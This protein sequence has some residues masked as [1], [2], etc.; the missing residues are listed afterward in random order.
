MAIY[1]RGDLHANARNEMKQ[2]NSDNFPQ[3][4]EMTKEDYVIIC[5]DFG[6]VWFAEE[7]KEEKWWLNWLEERNFTTL[8][9]DGNHDNHDRLD[10]YPVENWHGGK[11]HFIRPS[12]IHLMR[13][14]V[15]EI[16][17][18]TFTTMGGA[19]SHDIQ[20][21]V[22][23]PADYATREDMI[24]DINRKMRAKGGWQYFLYRIKGESWWEREQPSTK[25]WHEWHNNLEAHNF[26]VDYVLTH[27]A[28]ASVIPLISIFK[29]TEM[30]EM[31]EKYRWCLDYKHWFFGHY[32]QDR[33][34]NEKESVVYENLI[35]VE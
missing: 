26:K 33:R 23:D 34:I 15:Y 1:I 3:Q 30:S 31:L 24:T 11:V 16:N 8:F 17:G 14:Q 29:P 19:P 6:F 20:D 27:E 22:F 21:G 28:P 4:K 5:G 32:H 2:L 12:V 10:S 7:T 25:E 13:G 9:I 35:R 18:K